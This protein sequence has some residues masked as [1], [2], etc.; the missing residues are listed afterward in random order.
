MARVVLLVALTLQA[1]IPALTG[2]VVDDADFLT[3]DQTAALEQ[4]LAELEE[5][6]SVQI[7][8]ATIPSLEG[9][10]IEDF[11]I[12]LAQ[13]W[14]IGRKG[15]DNGAI[16]VV[17][18]DER[19]VRIEVGYG[20]EPVIPDGVAGRI[21]REQ[22]TPHF[23]AND[24]AGGLEAAVDTLA[25]AARREYPVESVPVAET[26]RSRGSEFP[27]AGALLVFWFLGVVGNALGR[28][29]A[30]IG[31]AVALPLL[32]YLGGMT[33]ARL[34]FFIPL[35]LGLGLLAMAFT[36]RGRA[37]RRTW[38]SGGHHGHWGGGRGFRRGGG[39]G[40]GGFRGG[41]GSFGGG[42]AS[43]SW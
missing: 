41:G 38:T 43:G 39:F 21:I 3:A 12:R 16:L 20:L 32:G 7:V 18:R 36:R 28:P 34:L 13:A 30:A 24:Y 10:P 31:G 25:L 11:S 42:G 17:A 1:S 33:L 22:I 40:G 5:Q 14:R 8:I 6:T 9:E 4:K 35:G 27:T 26:P 23:R 29:F 19:R 15:L 2:R 37:G